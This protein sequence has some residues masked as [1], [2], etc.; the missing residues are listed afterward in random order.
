MTKYKMLVARDIK[1]SLYTA[2]YKKICSNLKT[3]LKII[4][5]PKMLKGLLKNK[6]FFLLKT[7]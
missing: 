1:I 2:L 5:F 6:Y 7:R 4:F 3:A